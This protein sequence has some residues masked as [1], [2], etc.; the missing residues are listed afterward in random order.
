ML[1]LKWNSMKQYINK[2]AVAMFASVLMSGCADD[3]VLGFPVEKP[4]SIAEL[5]YLNEYASLKSYIDRSANPNFK[6]GTGVSV[7]DYI[8]GGIVYR[9]TNANFDEMTAGN[10]MK[11]SSCVK[12]DGSMAF[13]Q[14]TRF[15]EM[16]QEVG[17]TIYGHTLAWHSQQNNSYLNS[18]VA[19]NKALHIHTDEAKENP[20]DWELYYNLDQPLV[21]GKEYTIKMKAKGAPAFNNICFWPGD[22]TNTQYLPSFN[23]GEAL[24][25]TSITFT[26]DYALNVMRFCFGQFAGDLYFDDLSLKETGSDVELIQNSSFDE[27]DLAHFSKPSWVDYTYVIE[28]VAD[29]ASGSLNPEEKKEIIAEAMDNW[30]NGM[31]EACGGYVTT[32]DVVN[33]ALS[34]VDQDGDGIYDLQSATRGTVSK[35]DAKN[36]FYWQDYLGDEDYVRMAVRLARQHFAEHEGN[37]ADLKL[38]INDYNLE[39]DW[40]DN[41]KLKSLIAW[42]GKWEADG[43]TKLDGIGTQMHVSYYLNQ[44]IQKSKE[45]HVVK[46]LE[47]LAASGKLVKI[48]ELDMGI[49][50][51]DGASIMTKDVTLEQRKAMAEYYQFIVRKYFEIIPT[52]QQYGITQWA[53]TDSPENSGWRKGEPIGLWTLDY[54][55]NPSYAGF[56]DG[57]AGK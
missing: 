6:L 5:E 1:V 25:E 27:D 57:L 42:I 52:A 35:E 22:G 30:I 32:W 31:M 43:V 56:A 26:A 2:V 9:L 11:H 15:V 12:D 28:S 47:L 54:D 19:S 38:F 53:Q 46:M 29:G 3:S 55:R 41:K 7:R 37:A 34:G 20:W 21:V 36:N 45:D 10:A 23:A 48:S 4:E 8:S 33:E 44:D 40:D 16:A 24:A 39:S 13:S 17:L 50:G 49:I 18:L 14:V 51:M